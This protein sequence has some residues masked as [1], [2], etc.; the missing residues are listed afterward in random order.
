ML[1]VVADAVTDGELRNPARYKVKVSEYRHYYRNGYLVVRNLLPPEDVE[2]LKAFAMD[3]LHGRV[4]L[5]GLE[6]PPP[7]ATL[8]E[9]YGRFSR[10][11]MLHRANATAEKYLLHPR[12]LDVLEALIGPDVLAL[13][14]MLFLNPPGK[15]G[16]GWH[17]D[18][19][20]ITTFPDVMIGV[21]MALDRA[22][23]ENGCLW[24][25][26]GSHA[27]PIYPTPDRLHTVHAEET[28]DNLDIVENVS[29]MDDSVNTLSR[30]ARQ[31]PDPIPVVVDP[32]DVVFFHGHLLHR[33]HRNRTQDR[34]R[35]AFV[36]H[37]TNA[38]S[39][40][41]WNHGN[42]WEGPS[43]NYLHIL[44]RGR[45][46]LPYA[47]PPFGTPCAALDPVTKDGIDGTGQMM[48]DMDESG[49]GEMKVIHVA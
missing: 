44:A 41:P 48:G 11:H 26:P 19:Y 17:Q 10:I 36:C 12:A 9:L 18:S 16:Q 35:R 8:D 14:T 2:A 33:S 28:F 5:P 15:G 29:N 21:W 22:D 45:T 40:V 42:V 49:D 27:E 20:Y 4:M 3:L 32:G 43:A 34:M 24:V 13:Q 1:S 6:P 25:I 37:Y 46:H 7:N 47:Q 39:W 23:E 30:V 38:R 31:Y